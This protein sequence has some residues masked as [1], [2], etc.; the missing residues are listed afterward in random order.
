MQKRER[1]IKFYQSLIKKKYPVSNDAILEEIWYTIQNKKFQQE[2]IRIRKRF[3]IP[4][5]GIKNEGLAKM[6]RTNDKL[7]AEFK[8]LFSKC[9]G[10]KSTYASIF[11]SSIEWFIFTDK[12]ELKDDGIVIEDNIVVDIEPTDAKI[13]VTFN[14]GFD[15]TREQI[16]ERL[17]LNWGVIRHYQ[18]SLA[19]ERLRQSKD[20]NFKKSLWIKHVMENKSEIELENL[21]EEG[22]SRYE[23]RK[24]IKAMDNRIKSSFE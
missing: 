16:I 24:I 17:D 10:S 11:N 21:S 20:F 5:S 13:K 4:L 2:I 3:N 18:K 1:A 19:G 8:S 15:T 22:L 9:K 6:S 7:R 14:L 12:V 23:I